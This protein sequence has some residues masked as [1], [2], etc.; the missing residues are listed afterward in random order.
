MRLDR[1][2][3]DY[4]ASHASRGNRLCHAVGITLIVFGVFG[5]LARIPVA[6]IWTA[7]ELLLA[8][9]FAFYALLDLPLALGV[10]VYAAILDLA[11]RAVTWPVALTAFVVGWVFQAVGHAVYEKNRP[12]FFRNLIH[13]LIGP[14]FL[15]SEAVGLGPRASDVSRT[16]S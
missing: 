15:V 2:F 8:A 1:L 16:S 10:L 6:G 13:L 3:A 11:A 14:A 7:S 12:A 4:R 9:A 5:F